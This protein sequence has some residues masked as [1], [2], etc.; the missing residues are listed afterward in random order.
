MRHLHHVLLLA[1]LANVMMTS[2]FS[3]YTFSSKHSARHLPEAVILLSEAHRASHRGTPRLILLS[4]ALRASHREA[5]RAS[6]REACPRSIL[7]AIIISSF[8]VNNLLGIHF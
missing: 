1:V 3:R 2:T 7:L 8:L 5:H 4:E 6:H